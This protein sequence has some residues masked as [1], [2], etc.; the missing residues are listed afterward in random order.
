[1]LISYKINY[2]VTVEFLGKLTENVCNEFEKIRNHYNKIG[3]YFG[4]PLGW[5]HVHHIEFYLVDDIKNLKKII[6]LIK[7]I[8]NFN[9]KY[10]ERRNNVFDI[11]LKI[12]DRENILNISLFPNEKDLINSI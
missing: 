11:P 8:N 7:N 3:S 10:I 9:I 1:M 2:I 12:Y 4:G 6:K 5:G